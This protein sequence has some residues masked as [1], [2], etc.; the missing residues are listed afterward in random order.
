MKFSKNLI[1]SKL[2][3]IIQAI[4]KMSPKER[5]EIPTPEFIRNYNTIRKI[6]LGMFPN[7]EKIFPPELEI[8]KD[9][10]DIEFVRTKYVEV[11][12]YCLEIKELLQSS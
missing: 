7:L 8:F 4:E 3:G 5:Q 10:I 2:L 9:E 1:I 6:A 11:L 12:S